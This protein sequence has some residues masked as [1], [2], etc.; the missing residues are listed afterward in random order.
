[1]RIYRVYDDSTD[2]THGF[3][4]YEEEAMERAHALVCDSLEKNQDEQ[5]SPLREEIDVC[6]R[7]LDL[8]C[9]G[10]LA[11]SDDMSKARAEIVEEVGDE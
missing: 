1:M 4:K 3:Y 7:A 5:V 6:T 2:E 10:L 9:D 11:D 8:A